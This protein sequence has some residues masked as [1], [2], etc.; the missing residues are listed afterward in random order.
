MISLITYITVDN[1]LTVS[2]SDV[3][4]LRSQVKKSFISVN[5]H[6]DDKGSTM[7]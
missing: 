6:R 5:T 1:S 2:D 3:S 7:Y 4:D